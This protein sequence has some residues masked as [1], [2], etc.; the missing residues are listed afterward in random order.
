[1]TKMKRM[2]RMMRMMKMM[3][4]RK[5]MRVTRMRKMMKRHL[6]PLSEMIGN[7]PELKIFQWI[8]QWPIKQKRDKKVNQ[9]NNTSTKA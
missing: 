4:M 8:S 5:M 7:R 2:M 1:M 9:S 3:R 6:R